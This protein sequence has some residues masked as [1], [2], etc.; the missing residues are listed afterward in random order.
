M[1]IRIGTLIRE[2]GQRDTIIEN[3]EERIKVVGDRLN[4]MKL[5]YDVEIAS[6]VYCLISY[7]CSSNLCNI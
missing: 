2:N 3:L 5:A 1:S 7:K 4:E 6:R